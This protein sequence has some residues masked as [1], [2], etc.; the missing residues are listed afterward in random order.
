[1]VFH[2]TDQSNQSNQEEKDP[3]CDCHSNNT[4]TRNESKAYPPC[5]NSNQQ[6]ANQLVGEKQKKKKE[7]KKNSTLKKKK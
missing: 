1:M 6:Q 7:R 2:C 3:H 4:E 5:C